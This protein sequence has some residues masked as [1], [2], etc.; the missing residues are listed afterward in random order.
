MEP[1]AIY[2]LNG[3]GTGTLALCRQPNG[4]EDFDQIADW[5][6]SVV[7]THTQELEF[8]EIEPS[9]PMHFL[10]AE[11]DWLHLPIVDFGAPDISDWGDN[12]NNLKA[13][14]NA[15]GRILAHCKGGQGRSGMLLLKLLVSQ[16]EAP[17]TALARIRAV[18]P[19]AVETKEQ[20]NWAIKPL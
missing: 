11:Y 1:F 12:L 13:T 8:P 7:V 5:Q 16:G 9:L 2:E 14:L 20:Y 3:F 19:H 17:E 15:G 4:P 6:P 18:R 10:K